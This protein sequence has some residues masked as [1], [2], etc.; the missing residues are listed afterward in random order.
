M[1]GSAVTRIPNSATHAPRRSL[2]WRRCLQCPRRGSSEAFWPPQSPHS[3]DLG[4]LSC[5]CVRRRRMTIHLCVSRPW[6][7]AGRE[8]GAWWGRSWRPPPS[9]APSARS[10]ESGYRHFSPADLGHEEH[11]NTGRQRQT[12]NIELPTWGHHISITN[13]LHLI[14]N[15]F[16][17]RHVHCIIIVYHIDSWHLPCTRQSC[18]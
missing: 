17:W 18:Q 13:S 11:W 2:A 3:R 16:Y 7:E 1:C 8:A 4:C 14:K 5:S 12:V 9:S 15:M 6:A 10:P